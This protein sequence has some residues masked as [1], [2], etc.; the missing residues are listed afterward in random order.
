M[1]DG[2]CECGHPRAN[3]YPGD[4]RCHFRFIGKEL[5]ECTCTTWRPIK[6]KKATD[7]KEAVEWVLAGEKADLERRLET[8]EKHMVTVLSALIGL[9][10]D[11]R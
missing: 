6:Q 4:Q 7:A 11:V 3:H 1:N 10:V 5:E 9:G 8:L 2:R